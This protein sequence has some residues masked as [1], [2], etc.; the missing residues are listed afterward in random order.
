MRLNIARLLFHLGTAP[1]A[2]RGRA[3]HHHTLLD[4]R[5]AFGFTLPRCALRLR[6][7]IRRWFMLTQQARGRCRAR[8]AE[9][10]TR[11][12]VPRISACA[13]IA[14]ATWI[15]HKTR[16]W[17]HTVLLRAFHTRSSHAYWRGMTGAAARSYT[18]YAR[19]QTRHALPLGSSRTAPFAVLFAYAYH[20]AG[21]SL[22]AAAYAAHHSSPRHNRYRLPSCA[23]GTNNA[24]ADKR[25]VSPCAPR[26]DSCISWDR[27]RAGRAPRDAHA[28]VATLLSHAHTHSRT[29]QA[30]GPRVPPVRK[31]RAIARTLRARRVRVTAHARWRSAACTSAQLHLARISGRRTTERTRF[32]GR[33][34]YSAAAHLCLNKRG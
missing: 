22:R 8:I 34:T 10:Q 7:C 29:Q 5:A 6:V 14:R 15:A 18:S 25:A 33:D 28:A 16:V 20:R 23:R 9:Y 1:C 12:T 4:A 32:A 3:Q 21:R 11:I 30:P 19:S 26:V 24:A 2:A 27:D 13:I 31:P 17:N